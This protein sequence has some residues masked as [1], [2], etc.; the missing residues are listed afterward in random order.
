LI[1]VVEPLSHERQ[2]QRDDQRELDQRGAALI[3]P[4]ARIARDTSKL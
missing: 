3:T 1:F 2:E 4:R